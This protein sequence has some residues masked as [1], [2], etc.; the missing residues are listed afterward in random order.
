MVQYVT[1]L[2]SVLNI[3]R[4]ENLYEQIFISEMNASPHPNDDLLLVLCLWQWN[5]F[6]S[7][8]CCRLPL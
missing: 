7:Q 4:R 8:L 5:R 1:V 2:R 3:R 6:S